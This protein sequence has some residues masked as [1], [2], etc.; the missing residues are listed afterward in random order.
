W[1]MPYL[2]RTSPGYNLLARGPANWPKDGATPL[3]GVVETDWSV[4]TFT[5]NWKLTR[6]G[7]PV[8]FEQHEPFCMLVP[9]PRGGLRSFRTA[10]R[11]VRSDPDIYTGVQEWEERRHRLSMQKFLGS[12]SRDFEDSRLEWQ[13]DYFRGRSPDG[14]TATEHETQLRL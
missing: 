8:R 6:P 7:L 2:F 9:Q 13:Q 5:M 3:E 11:D 14:K 10:I 4:A 12:Y 1:T